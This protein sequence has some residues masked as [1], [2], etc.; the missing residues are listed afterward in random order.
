MQPASSSSPRGEIIEEESDNEAFNPSVSMS[1]GLSTDHSEETQ[2][3]SISMDISSHMEVVS[4]HFKDLFM[5]LEAY[6]G[7]KTSSKF[8]KNF[9]EK[10]MMD[11]KEHATQIEFLIDDLTARASRLESYLACRLINSEDNL[12][13]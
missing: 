1:D 4:F 6:L 10:Q 5:Q 3:H 2:S 9:V 8:E 7:T 12:K 13:F 11:L